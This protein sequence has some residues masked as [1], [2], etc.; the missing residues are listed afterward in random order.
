MKWMPNFIIA[1]RCLQWAFRA[2]I[3]R[4]VTAS[5]SLE[6]DVRTN[7]VAKASALAAIIFFIE[8]SFPN[9]QFFTSTQ[10][11]CAANNPAARSVV[12]WSRAPTQTWAERRKWGDGPDVALGLVLRGARYALMAK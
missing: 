5:A 3:S 9:E 4:F 2:A 1:A 7:V 12:P 11:F 8:H 6:I 10:A